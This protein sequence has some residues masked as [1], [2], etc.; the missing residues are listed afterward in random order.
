MTQKL[1]DLI[2]RH[3]KPKK[4]GFSVSV[5]VLKP[6]IKPKPKNTK[7]PTFKTETKTENTKKPKFE[8]ETKTENR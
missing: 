7:K 4:N 3:W 6:I 8:T 1:N 5:S 2:T